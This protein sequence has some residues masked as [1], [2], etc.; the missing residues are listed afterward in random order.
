MKNKVAFVGPKAIHAAFSNIDDNWD[1]QEPIE[2]LDEFE[3]EINSDDP[4]PKIAPDTS[5]IILFSRLFAG[6]DQDKFADLAAFLTAYSAVCI[7]FPEADGSDK[8]EFI[9][10]TIR[11]HLTNLAKAPE[12]EGQHSENAPF[13]FVPYENPKGG[14]SDALAQYVKSPY[15]QEDARKM[16]LDSLPDA[17]ARTL[18]AENDDKEEIDAFNQEQESDEIFIPDAAEGANGRVI[19]VTSSKGGSGKSTVSMLLATTLAKG[20]MQSV[21]EGKEGKPLKVIVLDL[22]VRDGQLGF[23]NG[24][25]SPTIIDIL[26]SGTLSHENIQQGIYHSNKTG[27]DFIFASKR[28]RYAAAIPPDFY[29]ML[30]NKLKEMYDYI[31]LDTSVN[32]LDPLLEQVAYPMSDKILFVTDMSI[33]SIFGMARWLQETTRVEDNNTPV[34]PEKIGIVVNKVLNQVNMGIDK[35]QAAAGNRPILS[36]FPSSPGLITYA[37]N[38]STLDQVLNEPHFNSFAK[39]LA[40]TLVEPTGYNL[41]EVPTNK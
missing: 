11:E 30:I 6:D 41:S 9:N 17:T 12:D 31:L 2:T 24:V 13:Y 15:A 37:A 3:K 22:D 10:Y 32:Y 23:L 16:I 28:P 35:I 8:K 4:N 39:K 21:Q 19:A 33:S 5:V 7:L 34:D 1:F 20:S 38:T 14:L 26:S 18:Q 25:Q 27:C 40:D 29:V 36:L